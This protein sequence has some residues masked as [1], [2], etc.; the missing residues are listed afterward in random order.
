MRFTDSKIKSLKPKKK[1]H[2]AWED[3][4]SG[5][6][7]RI[8]TTGTRTFV[9][10]YRIDGRPAGITI[11][12]YPQMSLHEARSIAAKYKESVA[13]GDDPRVKIQDQ[14]RANREA[15]S[16][17]ELC[18]EY[19]EKWAK[20]KKRSWKEDQRILEK[21]IIPAWGRRKAK[22]IQRRDVVLL[23]VKYLSR[24]LLIALVLFG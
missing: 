2:T 3:G 11:G 23:L 7:V 6:G 5:F 4:K 8:E 17:K 19:I 14:K 10:W 9:L 16:V 20:P 24:F 12:R 1:R 21:D 15:E 13:K 22:S 18:H